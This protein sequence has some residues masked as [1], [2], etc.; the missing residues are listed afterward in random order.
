MKAIDI[1]VETTMTRKN[2]ILAASAVVLDEDTRFLLVQRAHPPDQGCWTLPGGR[3]EPGETLDK[4]SYAKSL[5]RQ[6][7]LSAL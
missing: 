4:P 6:D 1:E 5:K 2:A 7:W 3:V